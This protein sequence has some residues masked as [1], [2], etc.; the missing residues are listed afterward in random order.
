MLLA[1]AV[2]VAAA[3]APGCGTSGPP[4]GPS[5]ALSVTSMSP[6]TGPTESAVDVRVIG[7]GFKSGATV[8]VDGTPVAATVASAALINAT[9]PPHAA[10]RVDLV[11]TNPGGETVKLTGGFTYVVVAVSSVTPAF[12]SPG[13]VVTVIGTGFLPGAVVTF[14]GVPANVAGVGATFLT[15]TCPPH[16]LG[17]VDVVVTNPGGQNAAAANAF[18]YDPPTTVTVSPDVVAAGSPLTVSWVHPHPVSSLDWI[19]IFR[20]TDSNVDFIAYEYTNARPTGSITW[21][22]P[23]APGQYQFRYLLDDGYVDVA[24]SSVV[25]ITAL[26]PQLFARDRSGPSPGRA[27]ERR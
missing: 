15:V 1:A 8:T 16:D 9:V 27:L 12:G 17:A 21:V 18:T 19:G 24:R 22:A 6:N 23:M 25:T 20:A 7:T 10:A 14:G 11:V 5:G 13:N 4:G 3:F 26:M 2:V